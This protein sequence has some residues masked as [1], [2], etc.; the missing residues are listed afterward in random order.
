MIVTID[1]GALWRKQMP[2]CFVVHSSIHHL[3][4]C[5]Y[6]QCRLSRTKLAPT[7]STP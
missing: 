5:Q 1:E 4:Q 2:Y 7:S 6:P 3:A